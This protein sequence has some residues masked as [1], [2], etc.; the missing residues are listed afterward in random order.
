MMEREDLSSSAE[1]PR[2]S[3]ALSPFL[4]RE[5]P[6]WAFL[7]RFAGLANVMATNASR[8]WAQLVADLQREV[9]FPSA[10][11]YGRPLIFHIPEEVKQQ[12]ITASAG[13]TQNQ[14]VLGQLRRFLKKRPLEWKQ[15]F[16][17]TRHQGQRSPKAWGF[18]PASG[19][20]PLLRGVLRGCI[21]PTWGMKSLSKG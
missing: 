14:H 4:N 5:T 20:K 17:S 15:V 21:H 16:S 10:N 7:I 2:K 13:P 18:V 9:T 19:L 1:S 12:L 11:N 8:C 3:T 6:T